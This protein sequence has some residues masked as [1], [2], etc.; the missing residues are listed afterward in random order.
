[1]QEVITFE[2]NENRV[3]CC[4]STFHLCKIK[5]MLFVLRVLYVEPKSTFAFGKK[6]LCNSSREREVQL[7]LHH[8]TLHHYIFTRIVSSRGF[9][10][11]K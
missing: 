9:Y 4:S 8:C 6:R 10:L 1:M 5:A 2:S 11:I 7:F 3:H